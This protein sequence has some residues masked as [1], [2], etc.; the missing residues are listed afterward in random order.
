MVKKLINLAESLETKWSLEDFPQQAFK[1]LTDFQITCGLSQFESELDRWLLSLEKLPK[2]VNLYNAFGEPSISL[3]N[4][5][6][7]VVDIYFWRKCDTLIHS[8]AFRGAFKVL[9]GQSIHEEFQVQFED[10]KPNNNIKVSRVSRKSAKAMKA[11]DTHKIL[12]GM[13]LVHR[14]L[15]LENPTV[16]LCVRTVNDKDLDQWHHLSSGLSFKQKN[17]TELIIKQLLYFQHRLKSDAKDAMVFLGHMLHS[18]DTATQLSL[19]EALFKDEFGLSYETSEVLLDELRQGFLNH[20]WFAL[21]EDHYLKSEA[22]LNETMASRP[23]LKFL[24]HAINEQYKPNEVAKI[25]KSFEVKDLG[26]LR[27][28]LKIE[29]SIFSEDCKDEQLLKINN[30]LSD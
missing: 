14:V 23:A 26:Q 16:S 17:I 29:E 11:G 7:F 20:D 10:E 15:H 27:D 24:A 6:K 1:A 21:Y 4:N 8:H 3:F 12:P 19:Y 5:D 18:I 28:E 9:Y 2:Q 30:F 25:I 22:L 13:Q